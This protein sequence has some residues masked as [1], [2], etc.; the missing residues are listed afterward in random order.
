[1]LIVA[2]NSISNNP[3]RLQGS[4]IIL[5]QSDTGVKSE[6]LKTDQGRHETLRDADIHS[7]DLARGRSV[8]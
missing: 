6:F 5:K 2:M 4:C 7:V 1:M 8:A 3:A